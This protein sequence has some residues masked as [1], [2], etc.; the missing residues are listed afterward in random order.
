[1]IRIPGPLG[2][3]NRTPEG[4]DD[5]AAKV[6][7]GPPNDDPGDLTSPYRAGIVPVSIVRVEPVG[8]T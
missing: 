4:D 7:T 1:M 6:R 3:R 5:T 2:S 8:G